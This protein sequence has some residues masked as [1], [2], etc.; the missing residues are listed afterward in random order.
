MPI[1]FCD[2]RIHVNDWKHFGLLN[3]NLLSATFTLTF[4]LTMEMHVNKH[5]FGREKTLTTQLILF[6]L[7]KIFAHFV[8]KKELEE[9]LNDVDWIYISIYIF[10]EIKRLKS[11]S[12]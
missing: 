4:D 8:R 1:K 6:L 11:E 2:F 9:E 7:Q 10:V 5:Q 12:S 3:R